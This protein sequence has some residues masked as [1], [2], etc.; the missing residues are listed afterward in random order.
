MKFSC[1]IEMIF[2]EMEFIKRFEAAKKAG[3][4]YVE[5]W[6]WDNK[7]LK[8]VKRELEA[9]GLKM[10]ALQG[11]GRGRMVDKNDHEVYLEDVKKGIDVAAELGSL[12][13]FVMS[14]ILQEDRSVK[15]MANPI[16][17][18]EKRDNT[19]AILHKIAPLAKSAGVTMVIEPLNIYVD[20]KGYSLYNT[21]PAVDILKEV[22]HPN[23]RLLYDA[24]HMQ[25]MEGNICDNINAFHSYFGHFHI[26]D[27][28]GRFQPGTGELNYVNILKTLK[29]TGYDRVVGWE[30]EPKGESGNIIKDTFAL[31]GGI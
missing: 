23:I 22:N 9:N 10:A 30:F 13:A 27:V 29:K 14:D 19:V 2:T 12:N 17:D 3:F 25:V 26:A 4:E 18:E 24:Y 5:F 21:A 16:S 6:N 31:L 20:H 8:A 28:P 1:C 15:P 11:N 7:D